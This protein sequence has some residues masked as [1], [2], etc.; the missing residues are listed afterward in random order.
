M[1]IFLLCFDASSPGSKELLS[2]LEHSCGSVEYP[3]S[4]QV[5]PGAWVVVEP[6]TT[7]VQDVR[8]NYQKHILWGEK[9]SVMSIDDALADRA[10]KVRLDGDVLH[11]ADRW[12]IPPSEVM[13]YLVT[14]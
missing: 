4:Q 1:A 13:E 12:R 5:A 11:W 2:I 6:S 14:Q 10:N 9:L 3:S 7:N 8:M